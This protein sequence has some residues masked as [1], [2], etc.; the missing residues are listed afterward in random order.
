MDKKFDGT[1]SL[2][3][4]SLQLQ[5]QNLL[6]EAGGEK[7]IELLDAISNL[8]SSH[9]SA[10]LE[11]F[12]RVAKRIS[13]DNSCNPA[14]DSAAVNSLE[15]SLYHEIIG[16]AAHGQESPRL[17]VVC[18]GKDNKSPAGRAP[19]SLEEARKARRGAKPV[20]N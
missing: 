6:E 17:E 20:L 13:S 18:G 5:L 12:S 7:A 15:E 19:I 4:F 1:F 2:G 16:S 11:C 14:E 8:D 9:R 10:L 3:F